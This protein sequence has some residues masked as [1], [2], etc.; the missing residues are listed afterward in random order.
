M[1]HLII[2]TFSNYRT[3]EWRKPIVLLVVLD[4][5]N[6]SIDDSDSS[7]VDDV[8]NTALRVGE[9][10]RLVKTHL[11][12]TDDLCL[13]AQSL[14][15][16][17]ST[18]GAA[19]VREYQCV[20]ILALQAREWVLLVTQLLVECIVYLHLTIDGKLWELF[21]HLCYSIL[22]LDRRACGVGTEVRVA[23]HGHHWLI[24]EELHGASRQLGDVGQDI[25]V[26]VTVDQCIS[27][28]VDTLL[29]VEDVHGTEGL[30]TLTDANHVFRYLDGI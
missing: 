19:E 24:V 25:L 13:W 1:T 3:P 5:L 18:I 21:L 9:V 15:E 16:F 23:Q 20:D 26:W 17:V 11:D 10:D 4:L 28:I 12:R 22:H 27:D 6:V 30:V 2:Y 7:D 8:L 14:Q 29:C